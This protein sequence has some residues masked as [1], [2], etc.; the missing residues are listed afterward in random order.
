MIQPL[1]F[2]RHEMPIH[3]LQSPFVYTV[4]DDYIHVENPPVPPMASANAGDVHIH[5]IRLNDVVDAELHW[6]NCSKSWAI[7]TTSPVRHPLYPGLILDTVGGDSWMPSYIKEGTYRS[8][9]PKRL[10]LAKQM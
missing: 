10:G 3:A 6:V 1:H 8:R 5:R 9:K 4:S 2:E 7:K